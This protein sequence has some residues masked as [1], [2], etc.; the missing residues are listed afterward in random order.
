MLTCALV[1]RHV[2]RERH[3][4]V[5]LRGDLLAERALRA[6]EHAVA[7]PERAPVRDGRVGRD[8]PRELA[9]EHERPRRLVLVLALGLQDLRACRCGSKTRF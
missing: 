5:P 8:A 9:P 1:V 7:R 3:E 4:R 2:V 6:A